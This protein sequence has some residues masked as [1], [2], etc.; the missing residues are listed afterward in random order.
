MLLLFHY[1]NLYFCKYQTLN[2]FVV[3][4]NGFVV[5]LDLVIY[6]LFKVFSMITLYNKIII[7]AKQILWTCY[8]NLL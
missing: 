3:L 7:N 2:G 5:Q 8:I 6:N 1:Y 4:L